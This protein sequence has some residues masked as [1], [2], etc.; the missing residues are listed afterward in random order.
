MIYEFSLK[1]FRSY[2]SNAW[3]DFTAKP[4]GEF[5]ETLINQVCDKTELITDKIKETV[6]KQIKIAKK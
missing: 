4:I 1:N 5:K 6:V 2:K 3:I